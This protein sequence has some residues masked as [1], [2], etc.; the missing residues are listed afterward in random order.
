MRR[1]QW[2]RQHPWSP[3]Q[4]PT[5][6]SFSPTPFRVSTWSLPLRLIYTVLRFASS[7]LVRE[8][9][10]TTPDKSPP[11]CPITT[12]LPDAESAAL[13]P[14]EFLKSNTLGPSSPTAVERTVISCAVPEYSLQFWTPVQSVIKSVGN[15]VGS[16]AAAKQV[17]AEEKA[18]RAPTSAEAAMVFSG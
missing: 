4:V 10:R 16:T 15:S 3:C 1:P 18:S 12:V 2:T 13:N 17:P 9:P 11:V 14:N 8:A 6:S 7:P 5:G